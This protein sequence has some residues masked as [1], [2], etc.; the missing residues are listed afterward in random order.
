MSLGG[1]DETTSGQRSAQALLLA[2]RQSQVTQEAAPMASAV[3]GQFPRPE[4]NS[5]TPSGH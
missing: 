3:A 1:R 4:N 2:G 5:D